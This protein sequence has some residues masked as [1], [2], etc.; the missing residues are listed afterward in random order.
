MLPCGPWMT[1]LSYAL[2][3]LKNICLAMLVSVK[4]CQFSS[5]CLPDIT[6]S[7][8]MSVISRKSSFEMVFC[9]KYLRMP[10]E[11]QNFFNI[12]TYGL[13][14]RLLCYISYLYRFLRLLSI[15]VHYFKKLSHFCLIF[16]Y[17]LHYMREILYEI[18]I[19]RSNY[20]IPKSV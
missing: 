13:Q 7:F 10:V 9:Q 11:S 4:Y 17:M 6:S 18:N 1:S 14:L 2:W 8:S 12:C 5:I 19:G 3:T 16:V 15:I 20:Q